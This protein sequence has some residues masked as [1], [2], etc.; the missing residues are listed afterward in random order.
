MILRESESQL[1]FLTYNPLLYFA[2]SHLGDMD[3]ETFYRSDLRYRFMAR[4][5]LFKNRSLFDEYLVQLKEENG[6]VPETERLHLIKAVRNARY[7]EF[8]AVEHEKNLYCIDYRKNNFIYEI[9][10]LTDEPVELMEYTPSLITTALI[11]F[12]EDRI[13]FDGL[14]GGNK[15]KYPKNAARLIMRDFE[16]EFE[17]CFSTTLV[18]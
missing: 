2:Y 9:T 13:I 12:D 16:F 5:L 14:I 1:F 3:F 7:G 17:E 15:K 6:V 10:G 11:Q 4:E 18:V 8:I